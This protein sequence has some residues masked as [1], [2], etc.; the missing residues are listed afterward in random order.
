MTRRS[1]HLDCEMPE[2][3]ME[4]HPE[5]AVAMQILEGDLV[6]VSSRRGTIRSR[7]MLTDRIGKGVVFMP[8]HFAE[9]SANVLTNSAL[10]SIAKIPEFKVCA[11]KLEKAA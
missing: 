4:I 10:D 1:A 7:V 9:V 3:I 2:S 8:F 6:Q 5:D 11:V